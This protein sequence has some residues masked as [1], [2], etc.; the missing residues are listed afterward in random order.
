MDSILPLATLCLWKCLLPRAA[1]TIEDRGR[2]I[3]CASVAKLA[4]A[5]RPK[6]RSRASAWNWRSVIFIEKSSCDHRKSN[7]T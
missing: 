2:R 3:N 7:F 4:A 1:S 5:A 6:W